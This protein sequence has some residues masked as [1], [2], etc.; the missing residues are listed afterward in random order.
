MGYTLVQH[1]A[2]RLL[3]NLPVTRP[4]VKKRRTSYNPVIVRS[5][6]ETLYIRTTNVV[7]LFT[8]QLSTTSIFIT[9]LACYI[10]L[11]LVNK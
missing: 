6:S 7:S 1:A 8:S 5:Q 10:T 4:G 2:V 3:Q 9:I 11:V